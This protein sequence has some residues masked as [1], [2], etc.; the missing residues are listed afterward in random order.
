MSFS[1]GGVPSGPIAW[2]TPELRP[3]KLI[4]T[5]AADKSPDGRPARCGHAFKAWLDGNTRV[6]PRRV[7]G[8]SIGETTSQ[9]DRW[10]VGDGSVVWSV[11]WKWEPLESATSI[12]TWR[13][14]TDSRSAFVTTV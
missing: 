12:S 11:W 8:Q 7:A 14:G 4:A 3:V 6:W 5:H 13:C 9:P 1:L 10:L 2:T